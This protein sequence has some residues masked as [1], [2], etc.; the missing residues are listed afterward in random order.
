MNGETGI[1]EYPE[2][3]M[4]LSRDAVFDSAE[5]TFSLPGAWLKAGNLKGNL[6]PK[7]HLGAFKPASSVLFTFE[8]LRCF[9]EEANDPVETL[10]LYGG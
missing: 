2:A 5:K 3:G 1:W 8:D 10:R 9:S 6:F 4:S 7:T